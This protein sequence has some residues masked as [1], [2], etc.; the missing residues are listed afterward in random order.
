MVRLLFVILVESNY[1]NYNLVK[2]N[3]NQF[4]VDDIFLFL[5]AHNEPHHFLE[6][7]GNSQRTSCLM[8]TLLLCL[9]G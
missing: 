2:K 7:L 6:T 5:E 3:Q 9:F 1:T 8:N 4:R